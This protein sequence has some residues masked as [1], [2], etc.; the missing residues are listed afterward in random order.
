M[1][2]NRPRIVYGA[3]T[4]DLSLPCMP[5]EPEDRP[6]GGMDRTASGVPVGYVQRVEPLLHT[7]LRF[8]ESEWPDVSAWLRYAMSGQSFTFRLDQADA[9]TAGTYYLESPSIES[10]S[11]RP[12]RDQYPG[13]FQLAVTLRRTTEAVIDFPFVV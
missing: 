10:G 5:W 13:V 3:T 9:A 2:P 7:T 11:V 12:T 8:T 6:I 1:L 4:L